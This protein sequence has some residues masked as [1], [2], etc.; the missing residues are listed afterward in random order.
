MPVTLTGPSTSLPARARS[1][2]HSFQSIRTLPCDRPSTSATQLSSRLTARKADS[3]KSDTP[4]GS[5]SPSS[6]QGSMVRDFRI[7]G[8][9]L[10]AHEG[11][12][13]ELEYHPSPGSPWRD[14]ELLISDTEGRPLG[15]HLAQSR[16][17]AS[18]EKGFT[19]EVK[20]GD[21]VRM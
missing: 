16:F 2:G 12:V 13:G 10:V 19:I 20:I 15:T 14:T 8:P 5:R 1:C 7:T 3:S 9:D 11:A 21:L 4:T 18:G 17:L 6:W